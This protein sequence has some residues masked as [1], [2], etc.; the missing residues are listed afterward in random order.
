MNYNG[1]RLFF[2]LLS[3]LCPSTDIQ[4]LYTLEMEA[5][6]N[7]FPFFLMDIYINGTLAKSLAC[8]GSLV[9]FQF[10]ASEYASGEAK[11]L[12]I[13]LEMR[14]IMFN[15]RT[16]HI[17]LYLKQLERVEQPMD[18]ELIWL[19]VAMIVISGIGLV[20]SITRKKRNSFFK[21]FSKS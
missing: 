8:N 21:P 14:D 13:T 19:S 20:T 6:E 12:L 17:T 4:G 16:E 15:F 18:T 7:V 10:N 3:P 2:L 11:D 9:E 1:G 5:Y